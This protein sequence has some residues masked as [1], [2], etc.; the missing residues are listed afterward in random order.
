MH[1]TFGSWSRD[2]FN[3]V[4]NEVCIIQDMM[5]EAGYSISD[6]DVYKAWMA[7]ADNVWEHPYDY[8]EDEF[9]VDSVLVYCSPWD[10]EAEVPQEVFLTDDEWDAIL[11]NIE[12]EF[13]DY[14]PKHEPRVEGFKYFN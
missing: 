9:I 14:E 12:E 4:Y 7:G 2:H 11:A 5:F 6:V 13:D 3:E 8:D 10:D 1:L